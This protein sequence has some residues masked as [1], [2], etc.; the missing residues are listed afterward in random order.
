MISLMTE[1][2]AEVPA[3]SPP[4]AWISRTRWSIGVS[5]I[6]LEMRSWSPP[7]KKTPA[8]LSN[9]FRSFRVEG[10]RP[11]VDIELDQLAG[12]EVLESLAVALEI[13]LGLV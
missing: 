8:A 9:S 5:P 10:F 3:I 11:L 1:A 7:V 2:P 6:W 4:R 13:A 12:A